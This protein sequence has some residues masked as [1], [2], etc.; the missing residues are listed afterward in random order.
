MKLKEFLEG[1]LLGKTDSYQHLQK[2]L[3]RRLFLVLSG[4]FLFGIPSPVP[5]TLELLPFIFE[6][7][8]KVPEQDIWGL[9]AGEME[10]V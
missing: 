7:L 5:V 4:G 2:I 9:L 3:L 1:F 6:E 10:P 8:R